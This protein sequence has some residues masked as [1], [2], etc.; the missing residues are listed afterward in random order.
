MI[1]SIH[2]PEEVAKARYLNRKRGDDSADLFNK[3]YSD[4]ENRD[5]KVVELYQKS[6]IRVS[7]CRPVFDLR[8]DLWITGQRSR[9][10]E[11]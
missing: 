4:Y 2:C 1:I 11:Y 7:C 10:P 5:T 3:R 8:I 9:R 6:L